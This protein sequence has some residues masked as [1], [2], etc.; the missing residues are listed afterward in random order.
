[1]EQ[2]ISDLRKYGGYVL[3]AS[4]SQLRAEVAQSKL[5]WIWW[6]VEPFCFMLIYSFVFGRLFGGTEQYHGLFVFLGLSIWQFFRKVVQHS[7]EL[8][9]KRKSIITKVYM[10]KYL[11]V[12]QEI[13][14]DGFKLLICMVITAAMMLYYRVPLSWQLLWSIPLLA[15]LAL[16]SFGMGCFMLHIGVFLDDM[17]NIMDIVMRMLIYFAGVFYSIPRRFIPPWN[18]LLLKWNPIALLIDSGRSILLYRQSLDIPMLLFWGVISVVVSY[19]GIRMILKN[20]NT[21]VKVV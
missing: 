1:M 3:Y 21:Y 16:L 6:V 4:R 13:M 19:A 15:E 14:V 18:S 2:V 10:P 17:T 8:V 7:V 5:N 11:L 9:R 12:L 20:E